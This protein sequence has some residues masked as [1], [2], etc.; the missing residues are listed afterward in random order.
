[1]LRTLSIGLLTFTLTLGAHPSVAS[2]TAYNSGPDSAR[3]S[4][5]KSPALKRCVYLRE[6]IEQYTRMRRRGGS[7]TQMLSWRRSRDRYQDEYRGLRCS[8]FSSQL[9]RKKR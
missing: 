5:S 3:V 2:G 4:S 8:K 9:W 7:N 6:K 1:M